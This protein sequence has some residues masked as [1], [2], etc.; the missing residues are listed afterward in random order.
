MTFLLTLLEPIVHSSLQY[1]HSSRKDIQGFFCMLSPFWLMDVFLAHLIDESINHTTS[2]PYT[3]DPVQLRHS[4]KTICLLSVSCH[5]CPLSF[6]ELWD[7]FLFSHPKGWYFSAQ[8]YRSGF[9]PLF[10]YGHWDFCC[11]LESEGMFSY[12][13]PQ[14]TE[15][16]LYGRH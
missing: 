12:S 8:V 13:Q 9:C 2:E 7:V 10:I 3:G 1:T 6:W 14:F 11:F 15:H 4:L 16:L 5:F